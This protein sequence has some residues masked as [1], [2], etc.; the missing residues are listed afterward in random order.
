M[1]GSAGEP[2]GAVTLIHQLFKNKQTH[3]APQT[4][5][6]NLSRLGFSRFGIDG[7]RAGHRHPLLGGH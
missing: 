4:S 5:F 1:A 3:I 7:D 2:S 6:L